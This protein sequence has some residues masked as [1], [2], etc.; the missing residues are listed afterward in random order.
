M[1]MT[2]IHSK[3]TSKPADAFASP[4]GLVEVALV[5][6]APPF[7]LVV[8][9]ADDWHGIDGVLDVL[10]AHVRAAALLGV[11]CTG[12]CETGAAFATVAGSVLDLPPPHLNPTAAGL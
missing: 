11:A 6:V 7:Q 3:A 1:Y 10:A 4:A 9:H 2:T 8:E 5:P 12:G